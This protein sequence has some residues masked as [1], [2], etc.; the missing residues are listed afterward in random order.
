M[1]ASQTT[2]PRKNIP[3]KEAAPEKKRSREIYSTKWCK[4]HVFMGARYIITLTP[5]EKDELTKMTKTRKSDSRTPLFARALLLSEK[6][7][8]GPGWLSKDVCEALGFVESTL[9]RLK[10][11]FIEEGLARAVERKQLEGPQKDIKL[12]GAFEARLIALAYSP[13]PEGRARWT[14]RLLAEKAI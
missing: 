3:S 11:R 7:P 6:P 14:V 5:E 13:A 10:K 2:C 12:D 9:E 4:T 8:E 1:V